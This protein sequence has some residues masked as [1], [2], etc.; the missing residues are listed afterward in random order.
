MTVAELIA[1]L[2]HMPQDEPVYG[3]DRHGGLLG[4]V[5]EVDRGDVGAGRSDPCVRLLL[6]WEEI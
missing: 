3:Y 4:E 1:K 5:E 2:R 6:A